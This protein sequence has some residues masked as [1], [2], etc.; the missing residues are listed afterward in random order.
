MNCVTKKSLKLH[1][2]ISCAGDSIKEVSTLRV[3]GI[4]LS[5]DLT[6]NTHVELAISKCLKRFFILR[7]LKRAKCS[8][9]LLFKCY[10]AFI[11]S[12]M[13]YGFPALCNCPQY[14]LNKF[15]RVERRACKFFNLSNFPSFT[16][17]ADKLCKNLFH[18]VSNEEHHPLR[19]LFE[20][21]S[22][23]PRDKATL[24]PPF[25]RSVRFAKSFIKFA[26]S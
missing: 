3:L 20:D 14:L 12:V 1:P 25:A 10:V 17:V 21:R 18:S 13:L 15:L 19:R 11:R 16:T 6:W 7:N 8:N 4:T 2:I 9:E 24:R 26:K 23:T 5:A 22:P